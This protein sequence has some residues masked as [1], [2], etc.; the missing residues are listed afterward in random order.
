VPS[1][2]SHVGVVL[3][4]RGDSLKDV[5]IAEMDW[6]GFRR[7]MFLASY[8]HQLHKTEFLLARH[9]PLSVTDLDLVR[10]RYEYL[11][12][13]TKRY[14]YWRL[15]MH[16]LDALLSRAG[17]RDRYVFRRLGA[18]DPYPICSSLVMDLVR[19]T[20][21]DLGLPVDRASPDD[22]LD[23][24]RRGRSGWAVAREWSPAW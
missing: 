21:A 7:E 3:S 23:T 12:Q 11:S 1:E 19:D 18:L 17:G 8:G 5:R 2:A 4:T 16:A 20:A 24:I 13:R 15:G 6:S 22:M 10:L 14:G 9:A